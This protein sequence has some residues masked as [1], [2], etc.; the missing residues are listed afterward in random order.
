[1]GGTGR[2]AK[3]DSAKFAEESNLSGGSAF[4]PPMLMSLPPVLIDRKHCLSAVDLVCST[5]L[6]S[7]ARMTSSLGMISRVWGGW[8]D[9]SIG[10]TG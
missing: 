8:S 2:K 1:M 5:A 10:E 4:T 9:F 3:T 6:A 7:K